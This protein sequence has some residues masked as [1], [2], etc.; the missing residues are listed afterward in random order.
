MA[1]F[2]VT[3]PIM[4]TAKRRGL[5]EGWFAWALIAPAIIF[6]GV[7]VAWPLLET[8]RL[9][10]TNAD[11]G[12]ESWVGFDNYAKLL[13]SSKFY[14]I[15]GRTFFWMVLSVGL[16]LI[17]GLIGAT[18]LN[19]AVPG[20]A[21]FR[22]LIMPPWVIPIAIGCIGWLWLYNGHFGFLSGMAQ[23]FGLID[24]PL[25]FLAYKN[26]AFYAAIVT[27][28]WVGTPMV[29]LFF[30]AAM[31]GVN[32]DLYEAAWVDG[33]GRWYRFR[34]ITIPQI[35]P[36]IVSMALLSAIWTFNSLEI[37]WIFTQGGPR[38]GDRGAAGHIFSAVSERVE[39]RQQILRGEIACQWTATRCC[40][41]SASTA[42]SPCSW[43][44]CCCRFSRCSAPRSA[45]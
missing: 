26:S 13:Q 32:R 8:I 1:D 45:R 29:S 3:G 34:R 38:R 4:V 9:S 39:P 19:A 35:M 40:K 14:E 17:V 5:S 20:R 27:D 41:K 30:L 15:I 36:V 31:Q 28:V 24:G 43:P 44:L 22:V 16:K 11:M 37:I 10:F 6:I 42:G 23:R 21:L 7:I 33:A 18:L 25:E 12:G 2:A